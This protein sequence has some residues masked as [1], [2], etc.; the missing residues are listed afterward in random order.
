MPDAYLVSGARTPIG[1]FQGTLS[2]VSAPELGGISIKAALERSGLS[3]DQID[4]VIMGNVLQGGVGQA[5]A[6][7]AALAAGFPTT[8]A[9]VTVNKVCGSGLKA[10]MQAS[11]AIRCGDAKA[12]VAGGMENM[13]AAPHYSFGLRK[14][15]RL[16]NYEVKD[17]MVHD[18]LTCAF[19]NCHMGNHA[20][21]IAAKY[22]VSREDQDAF[23]A[24][25]QQRAGA[26]IEAGEFAD[27]ITPVTV[28][29]RKGETVV[30]FDEGPRPDTSAEK[31]AGLRTVF[32]KD[33]T[34]TAGNASIISDGAAAVVV[35]D[36]QT[37]NSLKDKAFNPA[38]IAKIVASETSGTDPKDLFIA[39]AFAIKTLLEKTGLSTDDIDLYE[40]NE[41]FASQMVACCKELGLDEEKVNVLGGG[42]SVGHPLGASGARVLVTLMHLLAKK[43]LK[44]GIASLCLGGGNAVAMLI[45]RV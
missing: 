45:E 37:A 25:S 15:V 2:T 42:I 41:A 18:G 32:Q 11:Q 35:T 24:R 22:D 38:I 31:L 44:R 3:A 33:G 5:P 28:K 34:V 36:E 12:I 4:E 20:E 1:A 16:G 7:Q 39:P 43:N 8:I 40:I 14:G 27:E 23:A 13:T 30:S 17:G 10:V 21:H 19:E 26:A 29:S 6:R 9:A